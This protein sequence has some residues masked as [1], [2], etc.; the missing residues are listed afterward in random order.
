MQR[1]PLCPCDGGCP[2]CMG[3]LQRKLTIGQ[4]DDKY[5]LE[6]DRVA[7]QVM[8]M[9]EPAVQ[10]KA[11]CSSCGDMDEEQ[12]QSKPLGDQITPLV[13]R[14]AEE[15]EEEED[16]QAKSLANNASLTGGGLAG[17]IQ[18]SK[19]SGQPLPTATRNFFASRFGRDFSSVRVHTGTQAAH[20]AKSL[21][22]RAFTIG[23]N[24]VFGNGQ[25]SPGTETGKKLLAHELT[26][27]VQQ[28]GYRSMPRLMLQ[29]KGSGTDC[30]GSGTC[31]PS[32]RCALPDPG[33]TGSSS[34][35]TS[36]ELIVKVDI[37]A[38]DFEGAL[39]SQRLGHTYVRFFEGNGRAYTYGFYP[40]G[41][42]PDENHRT[43]PG[44]VRHPDTT[45]D[46]CID[47]NL[48]Y[49]LTQ[50][51]YHAALGQAQ[52][53]CRSGHT[54]GVNYT[55][56]T[57]ADQ[58]VRA[59]GQTMPSARSTPMTIYY[60][61]VPPIDNPNTLYEN[62]QV[63]RNRAPNRRFPYWNNPCYNRCEA[64]LNRCLRAPR[65][66]PSALTPYHCIL[67]RQRCMLRCGRP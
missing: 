23:K 42:I 9:P 16:I 63:E 15:P 2:R 40:A 49:S 60:Q 56:T 30:G 18:S 25:Y 61:S 21:K 26:H 19:A 1:K 41:V 13:Q 10:R 20:E 28:Q 58:V 57:F 67:G 62:I 32:N 12:I 44:C 4:P 8:R 11:G 52:R 65:G 34:G 31:A 3:S 43:V 27:V 6:A 46:R 35:S 45:H 17:G 24:V 37:E 5:E 22:A 55:C 7:D 54:Y 50:S 36:W 51:Q 64:A 48:M 47:E 14:Q 66:R 59:A 33:F 38:S 39:R 53:I 29:R